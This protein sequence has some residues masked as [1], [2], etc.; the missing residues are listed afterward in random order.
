MQKEDN[1]ESLS[2]HIHFH[3]FISLLAQCIINQ[4][5][6][7]CITPKSISQHCFKSLL[8][9]LEQSQ[10]IPVNISN[11]PK[12]YAHDPTNQEMYPSEGIAGKNLFTHT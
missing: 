9:L 10:K 6:I 5:F 1:Q 4:A 2:S 12:E 11:T 8:K 3:I 7:R